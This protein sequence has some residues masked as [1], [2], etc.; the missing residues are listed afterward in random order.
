MRK[1]VFFFSFLLRRIYLQKAKWKKR[2]LK[3]RLYTDIHIFYSLSFLQIFFPSFLYP[4]FTRV[5][6]LS[7]D[8]GSESESIAR[9]KR[10]WRCAESR[11]S[12]GYKMAW[13][14]KKKQKIIQHHIV[15]FSFSP[16][17][18]FFLPSPQ[19]FND[20]CCTH[21]YTALDAIYII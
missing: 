14:N 13:K 19:A 21:H 7:I 2:K 11:N 9:E 15:A 4:V 18:C 12:N 3:G 10:A 20:V 5:H 1:K 16:L 17:L 8:R 6:F